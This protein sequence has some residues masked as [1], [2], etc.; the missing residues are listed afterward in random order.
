MRGFVVA[1]TLC[2]ALSSPLLAQSPGTIVEFPIAYP[3][4]PTVETGACHPAPKGSTHE[5]TFDAKGGKTL[6]IT[7]QNYDSVVEVS[8]S[9]AMKIHPMTK[10]SGPHGIEFD[11][12]RRL[13]VTLEF[14]GKIV[15][16]GADGKPDLTFD[17]KLD[18]PTCPG[19][20]LNTSPHGMAFGLDG[21]TIWFTGSPM[22]G[23]PMVRWSGP[24]EM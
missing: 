6:W 16:L 7:G 12:D 8:E 17:V 13:W 10:D 15:R 21:K 20:K 19:G 18:C 5:I 2:V 9:G 14:A 1:M 11:A 23:Y 22:E 3:G 4:L 24:R